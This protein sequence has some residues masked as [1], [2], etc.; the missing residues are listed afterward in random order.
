M[1]D[2]QGDVCKVSGGFVVSALTLRASWD[3]DATSQV[4]EDCILAAFLY[5]LDL[6]FR[7]ACCMMAWCGEGQ[8][9]AACSTTL[10]LKNEKGEMRCA[11]ISALA[12]TKVFE[13]SA[14]KH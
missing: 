5:R 10:M 13:Q 11:S 4:K 9:T 3:W 6:C 7:I 14:V 12:V 1:S 8:G 2:G